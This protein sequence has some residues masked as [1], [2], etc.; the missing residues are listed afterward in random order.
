MRT[1]SCFVC[2]RSGVN[3]EQRYLRRAY[4]ARAPGAALPPDEGAHDVA[5]ATECDAGLA[6]AY[7]VAEVGS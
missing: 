1:I 6:T 2:R 3:E 4:A 7:V 5:A